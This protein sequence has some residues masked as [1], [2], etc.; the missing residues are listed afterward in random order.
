MKKTI[1]L[2]TLLGMFGCKTPCG[3]PSS[4]ASKVSEGISS[5]WACKRPDLVKLDVSNWMGN[6]NWCQADNSGVKPV[7]PIAS[8]LCPFIVGYL[9]Q[10]LLSKVPP[11]WE[12]DPSLIGKDAASALSSVCSMIP[13]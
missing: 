6:K 5:K 2:I 12:C 7:G 9:R 3:D 13:F 8:L 10:A 1:L 11:Q 4:L